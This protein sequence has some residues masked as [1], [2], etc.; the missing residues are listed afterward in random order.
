M[1]ADQAKPNHHQSNYSATRNDKLAWKK[2]DHEAE[3]S[4][5]QILLKAYSDSKVFKGT[6]EKH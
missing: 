5:V 3:D 6:Y 4:Y 1:N 2:R